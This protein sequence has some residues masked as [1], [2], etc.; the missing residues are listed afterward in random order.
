[1]LLKM[2]MSMDM[3][4]CMHEATVEDNEENQGVLK[5]FRMGNWLSHYP[6]QGGLLSLRRACLGEV[7]PRQLQDPCCRDR[8]KQG[9]GAGRQDQPP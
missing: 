9:A 2:E 3:I 6:T 4:C 5:A 8:R 7:S 1:M